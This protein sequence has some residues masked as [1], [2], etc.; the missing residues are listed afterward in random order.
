MKN[1]YACVTM[2]GWLVSASNHVGMDVE[3][4]DITISVGEIIK[5]ARPP[6]YDEI[7]DAFVASGE[8]VEVNVFRN[9]LMLTAA[10]V[11]ERRNGGCIARGI[12][13][14]DWA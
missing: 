11:L 10:C 7:V 1:G 2:N 9:G 3:G 8:T 6:T 5:D 4:K 14:H 12:I 13:T